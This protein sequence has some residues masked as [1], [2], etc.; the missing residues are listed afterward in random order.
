MPKRLA[1]DVNMLDNCGAK[2]SLYIPSHTGQSQYN[3]IVP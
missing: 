2:T 1:I 3:I